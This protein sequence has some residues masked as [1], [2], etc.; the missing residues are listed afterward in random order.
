MRKIF[1]ISLH[2][3]AT[4]SF[5]KFCEA[6]G[7]KG[8]HWPGREF[9]EAVRP[10]LRGMNL[11]FVWRTY[12]P[13]LQQADAFADIPVPLFYRHAY[14]TFPDA[15]FVLLLRSPQSWIKSVR[16]HCREGRVLDV[17]ERMQYYYAFGKAISR[18]DEFTDLELF[19]GYEHFT[20]IVTCF[21]VSMKANFIVLDLAE[22][23]V[24]PKLARFLE[25]EKVTAFP[26]IEH[27]W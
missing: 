5:I 8:Q 27:T 4:L 24:G 23:D 1:N 2:R 16:Y 9:D 25:F 11:D 22:A 20:E 6:N 12:Q 13:C 18:L 26:R 15:R 3:S 7:A 10:A 19:D 14:E 17:L 21:Y